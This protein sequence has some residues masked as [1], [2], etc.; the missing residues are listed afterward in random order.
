[1]QAGLYSVG[2]IL[3]TMTTTTD[4]I[5]EINEIIDLVES[6]ESET[7]EATM[8]K[9][10]AMCANSFRAEVARRKKAYERRDITS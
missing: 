3:I 6:A 4:P 7:L 8:M 5:K 2:A 10:A 1:M 9:A